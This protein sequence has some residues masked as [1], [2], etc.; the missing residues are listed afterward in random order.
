MYFF[1]ALDRSNLGNAKTD[2][3]EKDLHLHG[4]QYTTILAV[5][6]VTFCAFDLPS[7]LL[8]KRFSGRFMLPGMMAAWYGSFFFFFRALKIFSLVLISS[9][10]VLSLCFN[11]QLLTFREC[12]LVDFSWECLKLDLWVSLHMID[13]YALFPL[14]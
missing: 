1:N 8:L 11:V 3:L 2:G 14:S 5:F 10:G 4:N 6:S 12:L 9:I 7:N 13:I